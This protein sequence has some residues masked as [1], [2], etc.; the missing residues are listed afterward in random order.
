MSPIVGID[1]GTTNS[2]CA[3][4]MDGKP[5]LI[6]NVH[7]NVLTPSV[8]GMLDDGQLLVGQAAKELRVSRPERCASRFKRHMGTD[9]RIRLGTQD[10]TA[11]Q[12]S[13]M[14]LS[15]L[16]RDAEAFLKV[17]I[18]E[19]V[20][21]VP[22]YFNDHQRRA[23]KLAGELAGL[24]VRRIINEPTAAALAYGFHD[25]QS[26][27]KLLVID[28]GG[29]TFDVTLM[30]IFEGTLEI[31]ST[32]GESMLGGEDFTD[33]LV[34]ELLRRHGL[35]FE[36][37]EMKQP[38]RVSRLRKLCEEAKLR[39][40]SETMVS[41]SLP[42][43]KGRIE[44]NSITEQ[45]HR[46]EF[47]LLMKPLLVRLMGPIDRALRDANLKP[48][49]ID[50]I[51]LVGGATRL[52]ALQTFVQDRL[53]K[54]PQSKLNPDEVVA[55]GAAVQA[56][57]LAEDRAVEDMVMTDVCPHTLGVEISKDFGSRRFS[58]FFSPIIH[59]NTTIPVARESVYQTVDPNQTEV[60]LRVYQGESRKVEDNLLLGELLIADIPPSTQ[61]TEFLVR[62]T[63]DTNGILEVEAIVPS[64]GRRYR[65]VLTQS[66]VGLSQAEIQ[67]AVEKMQSI[68]FFPRD[69]VE[70][71]R[72]LR[73][74]EHVV[75]EVSPELRESLE[76]A[77]DFWEHS[78][79]SGDRELF[80]RAR[81]E[82]LVM[83]SQLG[84][85]YDE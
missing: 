7:G 1:L 85:S 71:Q 54:T 55:L 51:I 29:G 72:L 82:L 74:C 5:L 48:E 81:Q 43:E 28:L 69:E 36:I 47:E 15:S 24:R 83:L 31:V 14:V 11:P 49:R 26:E 45:I 30:E 75:G 84:F 76:S 20:I 34:S 68:K 58:G 78:M 61:S 62:F 25:R 17:P 46:D 22:A 50:E 38:L 77:I 53:G 23:T 10:F 6:P 39:L 12:L 64:S 32:S 37:C 60:R 40:G 9:E 56:A 8:V 2:L 66:G 33:R 27:K 80:Q 63:Y 16:K 70:N 44:S 42:D 18:V 3:V 35:G 13:S 65:T 57:L 19:A 41:I 21:T 52:P 79:S 67:Q 73:F 59:R 4:F